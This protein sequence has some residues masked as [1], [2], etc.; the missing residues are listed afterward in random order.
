[1]MRRGARPGPPPA[2]QRATSRSA[3]CCARSTCFVP[4]FA[5]SGPV[6]NLL[7]LSPVV[8]ILAGVRRTAR[9]SRGPWL[10]VRRRLRA[11]LAR[12]PL[13]VQL[14]APVR[15]RR[16]VPVDRRRRLR[17]SST[18]RSWPGCCCSCAAATRSATAPALIDSL[19]MTLGLSLLSWV[20]LI[21]P[22]L[23][24]DTMD[25]VA[26]L[27]SIAYP[28]GDILLLAAAIRLAVDAGRR[29]PGLL[30]ARREHRRAAGHR[31]RL[32]PR[33]AAT[34]PTTA[35][36]SLDVGWISFYLLWGAA[37]LHPSMRELEPARPRAATRAH[38]ASA[39]RC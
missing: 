22:Y 8:A 4:P 17:R 34:A 2:W 15:R 26:K 29:E 16:A 33:D 39:S 36:S 25:A 24:D 38:A 10:L 1:M 12:R 5:G 35:R 18:R 7:G 31:L 27:V 14:P 32:R 20:A 21:A 37:A 23:H 13:H 19:I 11:V 3:R 6:M 9:A 30:P 28:L